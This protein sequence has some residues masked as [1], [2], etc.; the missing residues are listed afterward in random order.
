MALNWLCNCADDQ[1][2]VKLKALSHDY[3]NANY[4]NVRLCRL[5]ISLLCQR[6]AGWIVGFNVVFIYYLPGW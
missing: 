2:R 5:L 4:V 6:K 3:I 1:T